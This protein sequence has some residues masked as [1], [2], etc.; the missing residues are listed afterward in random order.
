VK[1][2]PRTIINADDALARG[3][4]FAFVTLGFFGVGFLL[5]RWLGTTPLFMIL[6]VVIALVGLFARIWYQYEA[7]M[8]RLEAERAITTRGGAAPLAS[9]APAPDM[10][11]SAGRVGVPATQEGVGA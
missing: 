4:D 11:P 10:T 2:L 3:L 8:R 9:P 6:L 7:S 1:N 5:D